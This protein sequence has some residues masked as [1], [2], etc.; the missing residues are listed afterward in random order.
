MSIHLHHNQQTH[1]FLQKKEM[2]EI[3]LSF[4][5]QNFALG[6][7]SIFIPIFLFDLGYSIPWILFFYFLLPLNF[8]IFGYWGARGVAKLGIKRSML[9]S[10]FLLFIQLIGLRYLQAWPLL[11]F[12]LPTVQAFKAIFYNYSFNLNFIQHSDGKRRGKEVSSMQAIALLASLLSPFLG[13]LV[14]KFFGFNILFIIAAALLFIS[15]IPLTL[16]KETYE[17]VNFS[18]RNMFKEIFSSSNRPIALSFCGFAVEEWIGYVLWPIFLTVIFISTESIGAIS[19]LTALVTFLV[20]YFVGKFSDRGDK[21]RLI[22]YGTFFYFTS[23]LGRIFASG[24]MSALFADT[25]KSITGHVLRIPWTSYTYDLAARSNY[26]KFIVEREIIFDISRVIVAPFIILIFI[27][28]Y[29][30]FA[31]S[32]AVAALFS[33]FYISLNRAELGVTSVQNIDEK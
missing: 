4:G 14:I 20:F 13:G 19:S 12:I 26:F 21:R 16:L 18:E 17:Q 31:I 15:I 25:Y 1:D 29:H 3:Y 8:M 7:I 10:I 32:F 9:V 33:L 2:N 30:P 22:K 27:I 11:F 28:D 23:W 6:L 5:I 24:F